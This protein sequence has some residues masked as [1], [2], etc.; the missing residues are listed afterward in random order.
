MKSYVDS[1]GL[2]L[3][4]N[5][6]FDD[7]IIQLYLYDGDDYSRVYKTVSNNDAHHYLFNITDTT[8]F[9]YVDGEEVA[10]EDHSFE[11]SGLVFGDS[12][13]R[14]FNGEMN[15]FKLWYGDNYNKFDL[16]KSIKLGQK[17]IASM[18]GWKDKGTID[19]ERFDYEPANGDRLIKNRGTE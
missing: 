5:R 15:L 2:F 9:M 14:T 10:S 18:E 1:K 3:Y 12:T 16:E 8:I 19:T 17:A 11:P 7:D 6:S 13:A 4:A